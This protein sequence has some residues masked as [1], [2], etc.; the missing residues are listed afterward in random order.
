MV[1]TAQQN[2]PVFG[3]LFRALTLYVSSQDEGEEAAGAC[4]NALSAAGYMVVKKN[5]NPK[6]KRPKPS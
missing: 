2:D 3:L 6:H 1:T 5:R 4:R